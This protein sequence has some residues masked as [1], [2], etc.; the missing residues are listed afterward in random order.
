MFKKN[1]RNKYKKERKNKGFKPLSC[2]WCSNRQ[3][4]VV[5]LGPLSFI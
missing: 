2:C 5:H 4:V 1:I 3:L